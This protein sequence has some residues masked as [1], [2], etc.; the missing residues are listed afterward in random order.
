M[1]KVLYIC[2]TQ[3]HD[4][5][6]VVLAAFVCI[7]GCFTAVNLFVRARETLGKRRLA[8]VCAAAGVLGAGVW[9]TRFIAELAFQPGLPPST[10]RI[11]K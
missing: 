4:F 3:R 2:I 7:F 9:T 10:L 1:L 6:L 5:R 8:L 11:R